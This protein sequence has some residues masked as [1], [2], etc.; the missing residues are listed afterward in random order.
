[1]IFRQL[2]SV[3]KADAY[4]FFLALMSGDMG[5]VEPFSEY[6][7]LPFIIGKSN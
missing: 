7:T 6:L 4:R 5:Q 2:E 3:P 1:M